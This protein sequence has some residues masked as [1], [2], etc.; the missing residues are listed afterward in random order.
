MKSLFMKIPETQMLVV[1]YLYIMEQLYT[2]ALVLYNIVKNYF[3]VSFEE[4]RRREVR[5]CSDEG[6]HP[7]YLKKNNDTLD[8]SC[9]SRKCLVVFS[10]SCAIFSSLTECFH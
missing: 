7:R 6:R 5:V 1:V 4:A 2:R 8:L 9:S 10:A 3:L